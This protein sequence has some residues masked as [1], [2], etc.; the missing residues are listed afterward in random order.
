[1]LGRL[2]HGDLAPARSRHRQDLLLLERLTRGASSG[3]S[4]PAESQYVVAV[5]GTALN[6]TT[7][8]GHV[9]LRERR[10]QRRAAAS[11]VSRGP[12]GRRASALRRSGARRSRRARG[13]AEPD[14]SAITGFCTDGSNCGPGTFIYFGGAGHCCFGGT[15]LAAPV[16]AAARP[17]S[18]TST[19][20][21]RPTG[22][23]LRRAPDLRAWPTTRRPTR[24][25]STTSRPGRT[26]SRRQPAGT[27]RPAGARRTSTSSRTTRSTSRTPVQ[28][29][30][31]KG[32]TITLSATLLDQGA[33]TA[34]ATEALGH[35]QG[36]ARRRQARSATPP[37]TRA[38]T[39]SA[40]S[41]INDDPGP[42]RRSRPTP[43]TPR[44]WVARRRWTS[45]SCTSRRR[46]PTTGDTSGEY[47]DPVTLSA[48][49]S[50]TAA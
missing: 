18:G 30:V 6:I 15:S 43:A 8:A 27:R 19:T 35:A 48:T 17:S 3:C 25:T 16:W 42:T 49:L 47:N 4:Y 26:A 45:S 41:P 44:T 32:D 40:T 22:G 29:Q 20:P 13:R 24:A 12:R 36:L 11:T 46:S 39:R 28:R 21:Q 37:S 14:V 50:T 33:A 34:L 2:E 31:E 5:G 38:V 9:R 7:P 23:R 10:Q 1:M